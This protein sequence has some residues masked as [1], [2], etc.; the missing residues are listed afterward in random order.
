VDDNDVADTEYVIEQIKRSLPFLSQEAIVLISSQLPVGSVQRLE[1]IASDKNLNLHF[2][3]SPENLRLGQA[4]E[5]FWNPDRIVIGCRDNDH[6][7]NTLELLLNSITTNLEWMSVES[8]EM[9]KHAINAFLALSVTFA[10]EIASICEA[11]GADA[12]EV[13]RGMKTEQRIGRKAYL[14]PGEAFAGG[15]LARDVNFLSDIAKQNTISS[16]LINTINSSN[17][18]H[19]KWMWRKINNMYDDL[20]GK[21]ITIWGLTYKA[22][23]D[24]LR[25][26]IIVDFIISL[27]EQKAHV[28][29]YDPLVEALPPSL[30]GRVDKFSDLVESVKNADVLVIATSYEEYRQIDPKELKKINPHLKIIDTNRFLID[31]SLSGFEYHTIGKP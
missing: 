23:T 11:V 21:C 31:W 17:N 10:N 29:V 7:K 28:N 6:A 20:A 19:K 12:S 15:T 2:A 13:A 26:S 27:L 9:T 16:Q 1:R 25:R 14:S 30:A 22:N 4:L 5:I 8:A 24:T 18:N 3:Y